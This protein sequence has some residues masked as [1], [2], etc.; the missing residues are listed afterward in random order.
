MSLVTTT[1]AYE[2]RQYPVSFASDDSIDTVRQR[3][4]AVIDRHPD[5][6]FLEIDAKLPAET[7]QDP[8]RWERLFFRLTS[9]SEFSA[10]SAA[11]TDL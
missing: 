9:G 3:V 5:R 10:T 2:G 4:G 8:R 6:L 1:V 11:L 7:Y